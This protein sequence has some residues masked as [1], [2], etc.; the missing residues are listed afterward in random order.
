MAEHK[1]DVLIL[2][3]V[4][5]PVPGEHALAADDQAVAPGGDGVEEGVGAGGQVLLEASLALGVQDVQVHG[6][7]VQ[8]DAAVG[9]VGLVV[10]AHGSWSPGGWAALSPHRG[11]RYNLPENSTP[12]RGH[13]LAPFYPWDRLRPILIEAMNRIQA[14][15]LTGAAE[16]APVR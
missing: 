9:C 12:G 5:E 6:P 1:E 10:K 3:Q 11:G 13:A 8:I 16:P 2:A 15:H 14:L 4:G 7:C